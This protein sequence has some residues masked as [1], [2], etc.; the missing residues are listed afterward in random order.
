MAAPPCPVIH[1]RLMPVMRLMTAMVTTSTAPCTAMAINKARQRGTR[2]CT[3]RWR[4]YA[5]P[6]KPSP[7]KPVTLTIPAQ[8][9]KN[10]EA[11]SATY[12]P[13]LSR[14]SLSM[15]LNPSSMPSNDNPSMM[16][17]LWIPPTR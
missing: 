1:P 15:P 2:A 10:P 16:D 3:C 4:A 17:S 11:M 5:M 14:P 13:L 7:I 12:A 6:I 8:D 9:R